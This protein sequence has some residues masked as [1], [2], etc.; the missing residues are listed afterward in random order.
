MAAGTL[1]RSFCSAL[2]RVELE[3]L[4]GAEGLA[5]VFLGDHVIVETA[6]APSLLLHLTD[7]QRVDVPY[8]QYSQ[9]RT[10]Q[11][12]KPVRTEY[13]LETA[14]GAGL[15]DVF[16]AASVQALWLDDEP[17]FTPAHASSFLRVLRPVAAR[18][19]RVP[20]R[21]GVGHPIASAPRSAAG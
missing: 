12:A 5:R 17:F 15:L 21:R 18:R 4:D 6:L 13:V 1:S 11:S 10:A 2:R 16:V 7:V 19:T 14:P 20:P 9:Q 3:N 8:N